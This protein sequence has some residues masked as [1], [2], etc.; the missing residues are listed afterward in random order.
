MKTNSFIF[1][2]ATATL[3]IA[4]SDEPYYNVTSKPFNLFVT[5]EDGAVN[6]SLGAC[7]VG[8][9]LESLC[10][11]ASNSISKP[12]PGDAAVFNFNTS[13]YSQA[14]EPTFGVP[15]ILTWILHGFDFNASSSVYFSYVPTDDIVL[16]ILQAGSSNPQL[17]AFDTQDKLNIQGFIGRTVQ[18]PTP[19][20]YSEI[21]R[22]YACQT[23]FAS[24]LY[25]NLA[26]KLGTGKPENPS[27]VAVNVT[28][29][30][31]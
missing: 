28:R 31:I 26:W 19:G 10:L 21:Y 15:G 17:L 7:H 25:V 24:Y 27:C 8:A 6:S 23:Y 11:S 12:D 18:P 14:P 16:P 2:L 4:Q 1:S 30:F 13:I 29:T 22:W 3:A 9:A 5:S 20:T